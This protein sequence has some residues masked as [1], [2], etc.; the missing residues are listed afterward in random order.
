[1]KGV[2]SKDHV[3][4]LL[5]A[6]PALAPREFMRRVKGRSSTKL[7]EIFPDFKKRYWGRHF[8]SRGYFCVTSGELTE[9]MIKNYLEHYFEPKV[10]DNFR[11]EE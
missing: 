2:V 11:A 7:F 3:H 4:L 9:E 5:S 1:L 8:W 10:D 6:P